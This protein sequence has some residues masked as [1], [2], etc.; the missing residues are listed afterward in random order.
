LSSQNGVLM[1]GAEDVT[2][3][4]VVG[5]N[6]TGGGINITTGAASYRCKNINI[7]APAGYDD[8]GVPTQQYGILAQGVD[9][10]RLGD[11]TTYGNTV[12]QLSIVRAGTSDV[13][14]NTRQIVSGTT[15]SIAANAQAVITLNW[16]TAF[17]DASIDIESVY[18]SV[19]T[20]SLALSVTHVVAVTT[21]GVQVMVKNLSG[22]TAHTGT[23]T[24]IGRRT[25]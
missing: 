22:T 16:P 5:R 15:G 21:A 9:G 6:N 3:G 23:L 17:E 13:E 4:V 19:G 2:G 10:L 14:A 8:Q 18:V 1:A 20:S 12:K 7:A 11:H 25:K 24:V